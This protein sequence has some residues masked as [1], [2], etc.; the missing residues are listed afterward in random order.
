MAYAHG[1][2]NRSWTSCTAFMARLGHVPTCKC[3]Y[4][5][6]LS[7]I[8]IAAQVL[9]SSNHPLGGP[10]QSVMP[11]SAR[12]CHALASPPGMMPSIGSRILL[13]WKRCCHMAGGTGQ[14]ACHD[15][16]SCKGVKGR[17]LLNLSRICFNGYYTPSTSVDTSRPPNN[18][19][20]TH[21]R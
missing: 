14:V 12:Q 5:P 6:Y 4:H 1:H 20:T 9:P 15:G 3:C 10:C 16:P 13:T 17:T 7:C 21:H 19:I 11:G 8:V 2:G 18:Q